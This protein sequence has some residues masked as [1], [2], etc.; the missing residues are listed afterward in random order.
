M[1]VPMAHGHPIHSTQCV[2]LKVGHA[3]I[4]RVFFQLC[5]CVILGTTL[6]MDLTT[7]V[8]VCIVCSLVFLTVGIVVGVVSVHIK[9]GLKKKL[10]TSSSPPPLPPPVTYEEVGVASERSH[11]IQLTSNESY[12]VLQNNP[13]PTPPNT[14]FYVYINSS[15]L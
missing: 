5:V 11:D 12:S 7:T 3:Y 8:T 13:T 2:Y 14:V 1:C 4:P 6:D 9:N 10:P 15:L